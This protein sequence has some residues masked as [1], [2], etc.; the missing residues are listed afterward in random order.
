MDDG[1][2]S[3]SCTSKMAIEAFRKE[4]NATGGLFQSSSYKVCPFQVESVR[5]SV[6]FDVYNKL[7]CMNN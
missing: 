6:Y 4:L 7:C 2:E 5:N 3:G 1:P